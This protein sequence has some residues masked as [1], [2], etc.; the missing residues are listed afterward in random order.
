MGLFCPFIGLF[1]PFVGLFCL[2]VGLLCP[3]CRALL[4][5]YYVSGCSSCMYLFYYCTAEVV[6][7]YFTTGAEFS[8]TPVWFL[9][10]PPLVLCIA[11]GDHLQPFLLLKMKIPVLLTRNVYILI[12]TSSIPSSSTA[13]AVHCRR[14]SSPTPPSSSSASTLSRA[15]ATLGG[16][17][18]RV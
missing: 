3:F 7:P 10:A 1:C 13:G 11:G 5:R 18:S 8:Y 9:P 2:F 6:F 12:Y 4:L 16:L 15:P 17:G 14:R